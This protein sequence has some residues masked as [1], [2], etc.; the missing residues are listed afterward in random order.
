MTVATD[1]LLAIAAAIFGVRLWRAGAHMWALAFFATSAASLLGGTYH[2]LAYEALWKPTVYAV[3]LASLFLLIGLGPI[4]AIFGFAKFILYAIWMATHD[5]FVYVIAD[6]GLT[7]LV[8][9]AYAGAEW[10]RRRTR[11]SLWI[12]GSIGGSVV[13]AAIQQSGFT[14]HRHFNHNDIYHLIQIVALWMLH[15][16]GLLLKPTSIVRPTSQP[17]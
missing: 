11:A 15:R 14:L 5:A 10:I 8:V 2:G 3:G 7:L 13:A 12:L 16:G 1:Y 4:F 9:G 6:Y 17:T